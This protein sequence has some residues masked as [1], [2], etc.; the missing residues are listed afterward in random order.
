[1]GEA[2]RLNYNVNDAVLKQSI[3]FTSR[4]QQWR[5][6][7]GAE[8]RGGGPSGSSPLGSAS[9]D[10]NLEETASNVFA[11]LYLTPAGSEIEDAVR[12]ILAVPPCPRTTPAQPSFD[13]EEVEC[14]PVFEG[15]KHLGG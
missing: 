6:N 4:Q 12:P 1:M 9:P 7:L 11:G 5:S 15:H 14:V 2:K 13:E 10:I 8:L 3:R